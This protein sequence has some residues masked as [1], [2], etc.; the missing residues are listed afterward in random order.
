MNDSNE[1]L[2]IGAPVSASELQSGAAA[3]R[4]SSAPLVALDESWAD[5]ADRRLTEKYDGDGRGG[6]HALR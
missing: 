2:I 5:N 1:V 3:E 6:A 4:R